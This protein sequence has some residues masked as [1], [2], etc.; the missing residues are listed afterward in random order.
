MFKAGNEFGFL[1]LLRM[2]N[3]FKTFNSGTEFEKSFWNDY[4]HI[5]LFQKYLPLIFF[6]MSQP[7]LCSI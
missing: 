3:R 1:N 6:N 2:I 7:T 4:S 5:E